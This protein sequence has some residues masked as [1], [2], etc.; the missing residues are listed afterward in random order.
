MIHVAIDDATVKEMIRLLPKE[1]GRAAEL[2]IDNT[3]RQVRDEIK[4]TIPRVFA[5]PVPWTRNSLQLTPTKN[6]NMIAI[7]WFKEPE[8]KGRAMTQH[9]LVPQVEGGVGQLKGFERALGGVRFVPGVGARLDA[10]GNVSVGQIKQILSVLGKAEF[11]AGSSQNA[12]ARSRKRNRK[13]RDYVY[14]P[15]GSGKLPPGVYERV[16]TAGAVAGRYSTLADRKRHTRPGFGA[17]QQGAGGSAVRARGLRPV[18]VRGKQNKNVTP[19]LPFYEISR[20]VYDNNFLSNFW[21]EFF[22][23]VR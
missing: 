22:R 1:A 19:R 10:Y 23:R 4:A 3:A 6:H 21:R 20:K 9:Y 18:L 8:R 12:T 14:L 13:Q 2:A 16:Q 15:N 5:S 17:W 7:V 11:A